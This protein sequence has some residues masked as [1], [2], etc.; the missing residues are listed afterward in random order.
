MKK[1]FILV[2]IILVSI[3]LLI[4]CTEKNA[5]LSEKDKLRVGMELKWPAFETTDVKGNP[6]GIS[7][8]IAN[9]LGNYLGREV[10][11]VDLPFNTLISALETE[12]IDVIIGSMGITEKREEKINFSNPYMY[13]KILSVVNNNSGIETYDDIFSMEKIKFVAPKSFSTLDIARQKANNPEIIEFDDKSTAVLE[14]AIGNGDVFMVDAV[15]AVSIAKK[16]PNELKAI[17]KPV[18][19]QPIGMGIRKED[20]K[21]LN[22]INDFISKREDIGINKKVKEKYDPILN[23]MVGKGF[24]FYLNEN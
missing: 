17:Y 13:F 5:K 16:Y 1:K 8:M 7:V 11:I 14:L 10:E 6:E 19:V 21:L 4:G 15:S 2:F 20:K 23:E 9:E 3:A 22:K 18:D 24:E 12:K